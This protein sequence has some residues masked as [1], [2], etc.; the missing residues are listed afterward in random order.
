MTGTPRP[1]RLHPLIRVVLY[2]VSYIVLLM[3]V[4]TP[5]GLI[6]IGLQLARG[7]ALEG[8]VAEAQRSLVALPWLLPLALLQLIAVVGL[9]Y[10]FRRF[11][12]RKPFLRLGLLPRRSWLLEM[13]VGAGLALLA[14]LVV[15]T[16]QATT[17]LVT[18]D[19]TRAS[20]L[21][22]AARLVGNV[23]LYVA[24]AVAE[25]LIFRGYVL[26]TLEEWPGLAGAIA[27]S[28]L[29]FSIFHGLNPS[30]NGLALVH[31]ALAGLVFAYAY[32][33]TRQ[34]WLPIGLHFAWNFFQGPVLGFP[35]SG[36]P[37]E[38]LLTLGSRGPWWVTG[39]G[40]GP[41]GGLMGLLGLG[42]CALG[43]WLFALMYPQVSITH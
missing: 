9:T 23:L 29:I 7:S 17:G 27:G 8:M 20:V 36:V 28:A 16:L 2:L 40:F 34:L 39:A 30:V 4:Q 43:I 5:I 32:V 25:E 15:F 1:F 21:V 18:V 6:W 26:Q 31:L 35:V 11:I 42:I 33:V 38:G 3:A 22:V 12:D 13:L 14:M 37:P 41:E 24:V 10:V 19:V